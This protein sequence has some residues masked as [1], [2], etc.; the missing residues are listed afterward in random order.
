MKSSLR[1]EIQKIVSKTKPHKDAFAVPELIGVLEKQ[2]RKAVARNSP[3]K[4]LC[5][6]SSTQP[7]K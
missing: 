2:M 3:L 4:K 7:W 5:S 1:K 6:S